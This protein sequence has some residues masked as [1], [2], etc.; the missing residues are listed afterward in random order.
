MHKAR[1]EVDPSGAVFYASGASGALL[2]EI[3]AKPFTDAA[4]SSKG[5]PEE[6]SITAYSVQRAGPNP[7]GRAGP[8]AGPEDAGPDEGGPDEGPG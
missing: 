7:N 6:G 2:A 3:R 5:A 1:P 4:V 8:D